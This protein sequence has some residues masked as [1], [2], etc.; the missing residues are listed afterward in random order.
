MACLHCVC[1]FVGQSSSIVN[2]VDLVVTPNIPAQSSM[3]NN[4]SG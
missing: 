2:N 4:V 1:N 3:A